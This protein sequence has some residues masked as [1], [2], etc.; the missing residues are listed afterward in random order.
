M[1]EIL[2]YRELLSNSENYLLVKELLAH[3]QNRSYNSFWGPE[4]LIMNEKSFIENNS[5]QII[6]IMIQCNTQQ[7]SRI[8]EPVLSE[9]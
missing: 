6:E 2:T 3:A 8:S 1:N 5:E 4:Y 9:M 7:T